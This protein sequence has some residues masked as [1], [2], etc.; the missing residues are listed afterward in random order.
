MKTTPFLLAC[1]TLACTNAMAQN[2]KPLA[3]SQ[4]PQRADAPVLFAPRGWK[5]EKQINGDL[6]RD[7]VPDAALVLVENKATDLNRQRALVVAVREGKGWHRVGFN[8]ALLLGTRD[9]GAFYGASTT[10]VEVLIRNG[11]LIIEQESGSREIQNTTHRF[12]FDARQ[13]RVQLIGLDSSIRDRANGN[14]K[15]T[16]AN[17]LTGVKKTSQSKGSGPTKHKTGRVSR[18]LRRLEEIKAD[19]RYTP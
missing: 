1:F 18:K 13:N 11:V 5:I 15:S 2:A 9:G 6:N 10:P 12:R 19:E 14:V 16:S 7:K 8:N 3:V 4:L 17:Y